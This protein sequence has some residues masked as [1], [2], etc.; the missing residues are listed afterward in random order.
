ME[1][2]PE[3]VVIEIIGFLEPR[4]INELCHSNQVIKN[5]VIKPNN[6][7]IYAD[8]TYDN[9]ICADCVSN[10]GVSICHYCYAIENLKYPTDLDKDLFW[11]YCQIFNI[12]C[13]TQIDSPEIFLEKYQG[14]YHDSEHFCGDKFHDFFDVVGEELP[15]WIFVSLDNKQTWKT[16]WDDFLSLE[17]SVSNDFYFRKQ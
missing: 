16:M 4:N 11:A 7:I 14:R 13:H 17:Y 10:L 2:L 15:T 1:E 5:I 3:V 9:K 6:R 8:M 12:H